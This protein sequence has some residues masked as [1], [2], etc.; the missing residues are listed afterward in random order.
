M[1]LAYTEDQQAPRTLTRPLPAGEEIEQPASGLFAA[2]CLEPLSEPQNL[3]RIR[4]LHLLFDMFLGLMAL[5]GVDCI[6]QY[7][8]A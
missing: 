7:F 3:R 1:P 4:N 5:A 2:R 8:L 6:C